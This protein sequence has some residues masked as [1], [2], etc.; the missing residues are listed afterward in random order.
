MTIYPITIY[1]KAT[2]GPL[3]IPVKDAFG[4]AYNLT[5]WSVF[6]EIR[7][8][9]SVVLLNM[10]PTITNAVI[11]EI[12]IEL[13]YTQTTGLSDGTAV[14]DLIL[15]TPLGKRIGPMIGGGVLIVTP[16]TQLP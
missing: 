6:A 4:V 8:T 13:T 7:S 11:G 1:R 9:P 14:W 16:T 12:T 15:V 2:F 5:G 10:G 3:I